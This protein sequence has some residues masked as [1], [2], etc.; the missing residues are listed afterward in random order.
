MSGANSPCWAVQCASSPT[1]V[2]PGAQPNPKVRPNA[3]VCM[4]W[5]PANDLGQ[6]NKPML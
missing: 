1:F 2:P 5:V 6:Y 3:G 4:L